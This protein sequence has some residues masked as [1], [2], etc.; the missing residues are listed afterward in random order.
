[1]KVRMAAVRAD[2]TE[3]PEMDPSYRTNA[4]RIAL[5]IEEPA[6]AKIMA[7]RMNTTVLNKTV[8][9]MHSQRSS[10]T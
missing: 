8:E 2:G 6:T 1:M 5:D 7:M 3:D 4:I 10:S 9:P